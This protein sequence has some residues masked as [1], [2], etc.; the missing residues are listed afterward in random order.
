MNRLK[1]VVIAGAVRTPVGKLGGSLSTLPA[2]QLGAR[3]IR[4]LLV[5]TR[6]DPKAVELVIMG[7]A[8]TAGEGQNPGRQA[9]LR[10]GLPD[11]VS[12]FQ[13]GMVCGSGMKALHVAAQTIRAGDAEVVIAGGMESMSQAPYL[14]PKARQGLRMGHAQVIDSMLHDGLWCSFENIHMGST[15]DYIAKKYAISRLEQD[16]FALASHQKA[17]KAQKEGFLA[18]EIV[19]IEV[20]EGRG[21]KS[22][23]AKDEGPRPD[24]S[25]EKLQKLKPVFGAGGSVTAG[26]ASQISDAA[27]AMLVMSEDAA[28]T[29]SAKPLGRVVDYADSGVA[30]IEVMIGPVG[31][32]GTLLKRQKVKAEDVALF[33][34]NEAFAAQ[35]LAVLREHPVPLELTN[36]HGGAVA[37]GHPI[38]MSGARIVT[39][40]LH[41]MRRRQA[42]KGLA[43]MCLGGGNGLATWVEAY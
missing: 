3:S 12:A 36:V 19:P 35:T 1:D 39:A 29:L 14:L 38:G 30:P 16:E 34:E 27:G 20:D 9:A 26:N 25:L 40:L 32:I 17:L 24:T 11:T 33:E 22:V 8:L 37:L 6:V 7:N 18:D 31:A 28:S 5:R 41:A 2:T 23:V 15:G 43:A 10:G 21:K 42:D 13:V 4:A